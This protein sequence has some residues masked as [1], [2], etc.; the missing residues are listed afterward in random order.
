M[1]DIKHKLTELNKL[2]DNCTNEQKD[3][4]KKVIAELVPTYRESKGNEVVESE[5]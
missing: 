3:E 4:I 5:T 1:K 2:L